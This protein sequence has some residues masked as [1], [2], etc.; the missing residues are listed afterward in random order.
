[1]TDGLYVL[2]FYLAAT[3]LGALLVASVAEWILWH[4]ERRE[5]WDA[6]D[7]ARAEA[8]ATRMEGADQSG[9]SLD[10][11]WQEPQP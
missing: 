7:R 1:M 2:G 3:I 5:R 6:R 8:R 10:F 4:T 11:S 9:L